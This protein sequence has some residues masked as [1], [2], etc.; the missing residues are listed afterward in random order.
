MASLVSENASLQEV[1]EFFSHDR[2]ATQVCGC[3]VVD[4][5]PGHAVCEFE[6]GPQHLNGM[7]SVMGGA[8]FT[9]ADFALAVACNV[10][11]EPTVSA[12][13]T[14]EFLSAPKGT[15]L[16]AVCDADKSGSA[17]GFYT[18]DVHDDLGRHVAR[19]TATCFRRPAKP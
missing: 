5:A 12:S 9:L 3:R 7:G 6:V 17:L 14:I 15:R 10:G 19:M 8:I 2:F 4:F 16:T 1:Q 18:V 13:N 11:E